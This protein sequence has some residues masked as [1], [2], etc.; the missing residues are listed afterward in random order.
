MDNLMN[1][2]NEAETLIDDGMILES[3]EETTTIAEKAAQSKPTAKPEEDYDGPGAVISK[4]DYDRM[5][6]SQETK[7]FKVGQENTPETQESVKAYLADM[8]KDIEKA[9]ET[10]EK[11]KASDEY[12]AKQNKVESV[13]VII[14]KSGMG[15]T[16]FTDEEMKKIEKADK[17][18]LIEQTT[19]TFKGIKIKKKYDKTKLH[20]VSKKVFDKTYSSFINVGSG[21]L[22][23]MKSISSAE[24]IGL[25]QSAQ[26]EQT[27]NTISERWSLLYSKLAYTSIGEFKTFD[28]FLRNTAFTDYNV[29]VY[30]VICSTYPDEDKL[31]LTCVNK[32]CQKQFEIPYSNKLLIRSDKVSETMGGKVQEI[33]EADSFLDEAIKLHESSPVKTV[34]RVSVSENNEILFDISIPSAYE[35][36]ERIYRGLDKKFMD[37]KYDRMLELSYYIRAAYLLDSDGDYI[38]IDDPNDIISDVL[39]RMNEYQLKRLEA[40]CTRIGNDI[41]F[42]FGFKTIECPHCHNK[43]NDFPLD[44]NMLLFQRVRRLMNMKID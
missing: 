22:G 42:E 39:N 44:L 15:E 32:N 34:N 19:E 43:V 10:A 18:K 23:K 16:I 12:K 41:V 24:A 20:T 35:V 7:G 3:D 37:V 28:D 5:K 38:E 9:K 30:A 36:I 26:G 2:K 31:S 14:D 17:I 40:L 21:Y 13:T 25:I 11:I 29:M 4:E 33:I 8:D 6:K 1:Y 27:A